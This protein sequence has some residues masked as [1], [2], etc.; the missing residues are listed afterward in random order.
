VAHAGVGQRVPN[1]WLGWPTAFGP[2]L[3][4]RQPP[5]I[6]AAFGVDRR[7]LV[8]GMGQGLGE[9]VI[10]VTGLPVRQIQLGWLLRFGPDHR[11]QGRDR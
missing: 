2:Q 9:L 10:A 3:S 7:P 8:A 1:S 5:Q 11:V 4:G 6:Q